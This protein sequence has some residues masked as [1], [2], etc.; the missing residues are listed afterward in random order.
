MLV[1][2]ITDMDGKKEVLE[3]KLVLI[4]A[5]LELHKNEMQFRQS[6]KAQNDN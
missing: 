6:E 3:S 4:K 2:R 1:S 5:R